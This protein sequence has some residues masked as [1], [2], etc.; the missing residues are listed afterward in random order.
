MLDF[1]TQNILYFHHYIIV[2]RSQICGSYQK[3]ACKGWALKHVILRSN[4]LSIYQPVWR[5]TMWWRIHWKWFLADV[6][7]IYVYVISRR[8][9][10]SNGE[11]SRQSDRQTGDRFISSLSLKLIFSRVIISCCIFLAKD[12]RGKECLAGQVAAVRF[13]TVEYWWCVVQ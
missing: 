8:N 1:I 9:R 4:I 7:T 12:F 3:N 13:C 5:P 11:D 2:Q 6:A 10:I